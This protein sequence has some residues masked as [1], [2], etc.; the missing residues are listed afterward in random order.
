MLGRARRRHA[1]RTTRR[2]VGAFAAVSVVASTLTFAA[3]TEVVQAPPAAAAL[4]CPG[5]GWSPAANTCY[6]YFAS[7]GTINLPA[8]MDAVGYTI[9]LI[10]G[11]GGGAG[12][13]TVG[14]NIY[15][16]RGTQGNVTQ[17][18]GN[19]SS[20]TIVSIGQGGSGGT[21]ETCPSGVPAGDATAGSTVPGSTV[22]SGYSTNGTGT[23]TATGGTNGAVG[24]NPT[25]QAGENPG[26]A[27]Y[28]SSG[29]GGEACVTG[30]PGRMPVGGFSGGVQVVAT[31]ATVTAYQPSVTA[32]ATP[33]SIAVTASAPGAFP[34]V[35]SY[36]AQ[37][38]SVTVGANTPVTASSSSSPVSVTGVTPGATYTCRVR[39]YNTD[40]GPYSTPSSSV[41]VPGAPWNTSSP[42][43]AG[44]AKVGGTLAGTPGSWGT[45]A[46]YPIDDT[47]YR[48]QVADDS[49]TGP[50]ISASDDTTNPTYTAVGADAGKYLRLAVSTHNFFGWSTP[51]YSNVSEQV[52]EAPAFTAASPPTVADVNRPYGTYT[53]AASGYRITYS[54]DS[55]GLTGLP[56]G[57]SIT[58]SGNLTGTPTARGTFTYRVRATNDSGSVTTSDLTLYVSSGVA[59]ALT[60]T[61]PPVG[62]PSRQLLGT[63]PVI[64]VRD[65]S[66]LL[67]RDD[68]I[69]VTS[70]G[71][72]GGSQASG[73]ATVNGIATFTNLTLGGLV[74]TDYTLTFIPAS[75]PS[76]DETAVTQ[77]TPGL[78]TTLEL[79]TPPVAAAQAG[80]V[81]TTQPV[82]QIKDAD[83]NLVTYDDTTTVTLTPETGGFVGPTQSSVA[84]ATAVDG[85]A[86]FSG[87]R[88]GGPVGVTKVLTFTANRDNVGPAL[89]DDSASVTSTATGPAY[90]L[91]VTTQATSPSASG[92]AFT[93]PPVI[94]QQDMAENTVTTTQA[95]VTATLLEA[96]PPYE[97]LVGPVTQT[98]TAGVATFA[99]LGI[100]G[101]ADDSYTIRFSAPGLVS[102][103]DTVVPS[104]GAAARLSLTGAGAQAP[105][106][107]SYDDTSLSPQPKVALVDSGNNAK[108]ISGVVVTASVVSGTGTLLDDTALTDDS[109]IASFT[110]LQLDGLTG[111]YVL[112]FSAPTYASIDDTVLM[113]RGAQTVTL[114]PSP[115]PNKNLDDTPFSISATSSAGLR[116]TFS[117]TTP[118]V[119]AVS[120]D[121]TVLG[122]STGAAVSL[123][124]AGTCTIIAS[125]SGDSRFEPATDDSESFTV[126]KA[127]QA[128][129]ILI[130]PATATAGQT[131]TLRTVGGSG[132][133][134]VSYAE[135]SDPGGICTVVSSTG[136]VTFTGTGNSCDFRATKL[137][138]ANYLDDT[139]PAATI[140]VAASGSGGLTP[141]S[142]AFT[143]DSPES[144]IDD[145]TYVATASATSGEP[146]TITIT[147]GAST[148]CT[149]TA[150]T[151]PVTVTF[152]GAGTCVLEA[153]QAGD[154][155]F[156]AAAP[157]ATQTILV[158]ATSGEAGSGLKN[159][160][161]AFAQPADRRFGTP[162]FRL[163]ATASSALAVA[164]SS[165]TP[166]VCTATT[167]GIVHLVTPGTCTIDAN[168]AGDATY[169]TADPVTRSF[170]VT[171]GLPSAPRILS[172]SAGTGAA[173]LYFV[174]PDDTGGS[175][176]VAFTILATP[177]GGGSTVS[178]SACSG[179]PCTI[180]GLTDDTAYTLQIAAINGIGTGPYSSASAPV[181]PKTCGL[182]VG[183]P[184]GPGM[185]GGPVG[186]RL[187]DTTILLSWSQ[188]S[189]LGGGTFVA[190]DVY[191]RVVGTAWPST[192]HVSVTP[193]TTTSTIVTGLTPGVVYEF[194]IV[195]VTT[196][197]PRQSPP[198]PEAPNASTVTV[199]TPTAPT[200]P[201][202]LSALYVT[203]TSIVVSWAYPASDGGAPITGYTVNFSPLAAC[204]PIVLDDTSRTASCIVTG[205]TTGTTYGFTVTATNSVGTGAAAALTY[206]TPG[207]APVP[208]TPPG[209]TPVPPTPPGPQPVP[210][211]PPAPGEVEVIVDGDQLT[212]TTTSTGDD[213]VTVSADDEASG[214]GGFTLTLSTYLGGQRLP[215]G[216]DKVLTV[217]VRGQVQ[218]DGTGYAPVSQVSVYIGGSPL[219]L[220]GTVRVGVSGAFSGRFTL[221]ASV[222]AGDYVLQVNGYNAAAK[223][224]SVNAGLRVT[225]TPWITI[226]GS[227]DGRIV[228]VDGL[229]GELTPGTLVVPMVKLAKG[230]NF[231]KGVGVRKVRADGTF[232]WQRQVKVGKSAWVYFTV[233]PVK[234]NTLA[235]P[236]PKA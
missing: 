181:E 124:G 19:Q 88:F 47:E 214:G 16:G 30:A 31:M 123:R 71:L 201:Q 119:C 8:G 14:F 167:G 24:G 125:Q 7:P 98:T 132:T 194:L 210:A 5:G 52:T 61:Q 111:T 156:A 43:I 104:V 100:S 127:S 20:F 221:P 211:P 81:M 212:E 140:T 122:G 77:V 59:H 223:V 116:V 187:D 78:A 131:V 54:D 115:I 64:E 74:N 133:G 225:E 166:S 46:G 117:T 67:V 222:T 173:T 118:T 95:T 45:P 51:S 197:N 209:P 205:L 227:R 231:V 28:G 213:T 188:P 3:V 151:S 198:G 193:I 154:S 35:S 114:S 199:G 34:A 216:P 136:E 179:S 229:C 23:A 76:A 4:T 190:Y 185:P 83:G 170:T 139:S 180:T 121:D 112:R 25:A 72:I 2:G 143:S 186:E 12:G 158:Y 120:G 175:A 101:T 191:Y 220:L 21:N 150:G 57:M 177:T 148:V 142:V 149:A 204:V 138:D 80:D 68:T 208:P 178:T 195:V 94:E 60:I 85:V 50:W 82:V 228:S 89:T 163:S 69:S 226:E 79:T 106:N 103:D 84:T 15:G 87:V 235:M 134:A 11:G 217:P 93:Q 96:T 234:S 53:F 97:V 9:T 75:N 91:V 105:G 86:T 196:S 233:V 161:I 99:G 110:D 29:Q 218:V 102:A 49:V 1:A 33:A 168:Q 146:V 153:S 113:L 18:S 157:P 17:V 155:R 126:S 206:T 65:D 58:S 63:Q 90:K 172:S 37:C 219:V 128:P 129:L 10:G 152:V 165:A 200:A 189:S 224:R 107:A 108:W 135:T 169:A 40:Y 171:A 176:I 44:T 56:P 13:Q 36:E 141:Q 162:D 92:A 174:P 203:D 70:T 215:L 62:G 182:C 230:G 66:G 145:D 137:G 41:L 32:Y 184:G 27:S 55:T 48:W 109:G 147:G 164:F 38:S 26:Y 42:T 202:D 6:Q 39:A 144:P 183:G 73:L 159:Q 192:P 236:A 160:T 232:T 207:V 130:A 22:V